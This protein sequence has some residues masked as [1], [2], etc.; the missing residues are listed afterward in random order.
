MPELEVLFNPLL[1]LRL[2]KLSS[3]SF[4]IKRPVWSKAF[5][6]RLWQQCC[7]SCRALI[8]PDYQI[9]WPSGKWQARRILFFPVFLHP[10]IGREPSLQFEVISMYSDYCLPS[11]AELLYKNSWHDSTTVSR[12]RSMA[13]E[14]AVITLE[15]LG[16]RRFAQ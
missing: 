6:P 3:Q 11:D 2:K 15:E 12:R 5:L 16:V 7:Q 4:S 9:S 8:S 13:G 14:Q 1:L 10:K